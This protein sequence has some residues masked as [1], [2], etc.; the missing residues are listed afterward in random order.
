MKKWLRAFLAL[1]MLSGGSWLH[2]AQDEL[3]ELQM[4]LGSE[5]ALVKNDKMRNIRTYARVENGKQYRSFKATVTMKDVHPDTLVRVLLDFNNYH[6]WYWQVL[7]SK[8]IRSTSPTEYFVYLVHKAPAGLPDRDVIL[9]AEVELQTA[10]RNYVTLRVKADPN[11]LP[12]KPPLV[13]MPAEDLAVKFIPLVGGDIQVEAEGYVDPGGNV[14][15]WAA[16][17][18]QH[19]APYSVIMG[20]L[21]MVKKEEYARANEPL[22]FEI[23][24]YGEYL[25]KQKAGA[26]SLR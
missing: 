14:P 20:L 18:V 13:R 8:L 7:E 15:T 11:L 16:N 19:S 12:T 5:W 25:M 9:H 23:Y 3:E 24:T 2:A 17:F 1:T 21:R 10:S 26:L 22:P 4:K 6:K